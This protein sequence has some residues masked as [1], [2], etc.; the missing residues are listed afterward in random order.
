MD[1]YQTMEPEAVLFLSRKDDNTV[2]YNLAEIFAKFNFF[3]SSSVWKINWTL[4]PERNILDPDPFK[5]NTDSWTVAD[6]SYVL[7][8]ATLELIW[9]ICTSNYSA[10]AF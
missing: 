4:Q 1:P 9:I 8:S 2:Q 6:L 5:T 3:Y 7:L 10:V